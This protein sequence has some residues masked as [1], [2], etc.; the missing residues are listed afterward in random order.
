MKRLGFYPGCCLIG[1]SKEYNDSVK[2]LA[3][4][5]DIELIEVPD[6]NCC[7]ANSA[8][9]LNKELSL[10]LPARILALAEKEG[11][12]EVVVPC[13]CCFGRLATT[14]H[15]LNENPKVKARVA[16]IIEMEYKGTTKLLNVIQMIDKYING[17]IEKK[18]VKK[19]EHKVACYYG[20]LLIR[21]HKILKFDRQEDP[22]TLDVLMK[23]AGAEPIDWAFKTECCGAGFAVPLTD[24]VERLS[25]AIVDDAVSRGAEAIIV[26]CPLCLSNLDM[27]RPGMKKY[28]KHK[29]DIPIMYITEAIG[30]ATGIDF[31]ELGLHKHYMPV[32]LKSCS[33]CQ[34]ATANN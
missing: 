16:E 10:S 5:F 8:Q 9:N 11:L 27:R 22:Q 20:C 31:K 18:V 19:F 32:H 25:A 15:E 13:A 1:T 26:A 21:P 28:M 29:S 3:K 4:K 7:G 33:N 23:K 2:A 24:V 14:Q 34:T 30:Q 12:E 17:D 6:W